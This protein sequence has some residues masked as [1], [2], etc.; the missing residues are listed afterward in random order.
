MVPAKLTREQAA[1]LRDSI[2]PQ[3]SYSG[4]L[5]EQLEEVAFAGDDALFRSVCEAH[6]AMHEQSVRT[7]YLSCDGGV[8]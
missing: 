6:D 4:R 3:L 8:R 2:H 5:R 1:A 7:H